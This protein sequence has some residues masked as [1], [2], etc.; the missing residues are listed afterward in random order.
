MNAIIM[1]EIIMN[2]II[3]II[4]IILLLVYTSGHNPKLV[5]RK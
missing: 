4:N 5:N 3:N 1:K 2:E